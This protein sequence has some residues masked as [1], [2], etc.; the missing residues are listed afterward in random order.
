MT[1]PA[2]VLSFPVTAVPELVQCA[3][4]CGRTERVLVPTLIGGTR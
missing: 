2:P 4:G 1:A 3:C